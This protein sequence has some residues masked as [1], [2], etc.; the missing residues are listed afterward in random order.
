MDEFHTQT[1]AVQ[2]PLTTLGEELGS[3][4]KD[5]L[6]QVAKTSRRSQRRAAFQRAKPYVIPATLGVA[7]AFTWWAFSCRKEG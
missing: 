1:G 6:Q 5:L 2:A 3:E 4:A 7:L